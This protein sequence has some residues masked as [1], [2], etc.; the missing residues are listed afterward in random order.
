M[1]GPRIGQAGPGDFGRDGARARTIGWR[2]CRLPANRARRDR[3]MT[4]RLVADV[5]NRV[6]SG[7]CACR[8][9]YRL[10]RFRPTIL[11]HGAANSLN[12]LSTARPNGPSL[13]SNRHIGTNSR[14]GC[15]H[16]VRYR[17]S[18]RRLSRVAN[19]HGFDRSR[20]G[21]HRPAAECPG[22]DCQSPAEYT[23]DRD[24]CWLRGDG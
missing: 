15:E 19:P 16:A 24:R 18:Y 10:R 21:R 13:E 3:P 17:P 1:A 14:R 8:V 20:Q 12:G 2:R 9:P 4:A 11:P 23:R 6:S 7:G 5:G 22:G